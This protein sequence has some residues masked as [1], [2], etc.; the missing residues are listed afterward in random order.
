MMNMTENDR[1]VR[2]LFKI[3]IM[4]ITLNILNF[5]AHNIF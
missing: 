4:I 1:N 2:K 5:N 3:R